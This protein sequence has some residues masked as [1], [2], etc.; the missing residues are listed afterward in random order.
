MKI[1]E[2][3]CDGGAVRCDARPSS[4]EE[5]RGLSVVWINILVESKSENKFWAR[6]FAML[7]SRRKQFGHVSLSA[8]YRTSILPAP[9]QTH[10]H[11]DRQTY[12]H[13]YISGKAEADFRFAIY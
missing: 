12:L 7:L 3:A 1:K 11:T 13:T 4:D 10:T 2:F 9:R 8:R 6:A 5:D